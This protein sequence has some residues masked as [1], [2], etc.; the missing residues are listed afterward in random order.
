MALKNFKRVFT[1]D[2]AYLVLSVNGNTDKYGKVTVGK[3]DDSKEIEKNT[4]TGD[5]DKDLRDSLKASEADLIYD[6]SD[7]KN[8]KDRKKGFVFKDP[9]AGTE[10]RVNA[11]NTIIY[12]NVEVLGVDIHALYMS[13]DKRL[14]GKGSVDSS[15]IKNE[16]IQSA[17]EFANIEGLKGELGCDVNGVQQRSL[18]YLT[19]ENRIDKK[20][21]AEAKTAWENAKAGEEKDKALK[22]YFSLA[23][24]YLR[25][26][27]ENKLASEMAD[28]KKEVDDIEAEI[29]KKDWQAEDSF[30]ESLGIRFKKASLIHYEAEDVDKNFNELLNELKTNIEANSKLLSPPDT[31]AGTVEKEKKE[32]KPV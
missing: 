22:K 6:I 27:E 1:A 25:W 8:C 10:L 9:A 23:K 30:L 24:A 26:V 19:L 18:Y 5:D 2:K 12:G 14:I 32:K 20:D 28:A 4:L 31:E 15:R 3:D 17:L 7:V 21:V 13:A 29:N 11:S 16:S